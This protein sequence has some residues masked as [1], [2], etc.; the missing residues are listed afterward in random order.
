MDQKSFVT[1]GP[2]LFQLRLQL[3]DFLVKLPVGRFEPDVNGGKLFFSSSL[4][5]RQE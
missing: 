1:L 2:G 5:L 3:E 4:T